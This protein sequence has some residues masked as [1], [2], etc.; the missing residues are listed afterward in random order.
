[1]YSTDHMENA[2]KAVKDGMSYGEAS[3]KFGVPRITFLYKSQGK[4]KKS[5]TWPDVVFSF[6]EEKLLI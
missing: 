3:K 1:M 2:V 4:C 6:D 5:K